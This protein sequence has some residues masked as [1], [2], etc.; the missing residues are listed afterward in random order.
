MAEDNV[1]VVRR[2]YDAFSRGDFPAVLEMMDPEIEW[3]DQDSLPWGGAYRGHEAFGQHMQRFGANFEEFRIEPR[4][5]LDAGDRVV[6]LGRFAGRAA[7]GEFDVGL[8][9]V[10]TLRDGKAVRVE[11]YLDTAKVLEALGR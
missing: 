3:V 11:S 9:H 6:V 1:G 10:W 5:F 8:A 4:D 2:S 7:G